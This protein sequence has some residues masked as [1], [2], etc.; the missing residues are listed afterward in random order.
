MYDYIFL[1]LEYIEKSCVIYLIAQL[2]LCTDCT[3]FKHFCLKLLDL[4]SPAAYLFATEFAKIHFFYKCIE[5]VSKN[6]N[7]GSNLKDLIYTS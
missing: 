6:T 5:L 3:G 2:M 4:S 7:A 1:L